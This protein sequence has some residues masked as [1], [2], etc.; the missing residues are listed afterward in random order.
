MPDG[1][2][3]APGTL[4]DAVYNWFLKYNIPIHGLQYQI[5]QNRMDDIILNLAGRKLNSNEIILIEKQ[6][7]EILGDNINVNINFLEQLENKNWKHKCVIS[8]VN[9]SGD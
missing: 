5:I 8:H 6:L 4:M 7:K 3:V 1:K 2:V 9:K